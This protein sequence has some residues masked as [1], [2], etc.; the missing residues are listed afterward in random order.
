[1]IILK[2]PNKRL[3]DDI[4]KALAECELKQASSDTKKANSF[5]LSFWFSENGIAIPFIYMPLRQTSIVTTIL[6]TR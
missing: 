5:P 6:R 3:L 4:M 2:S 1:M